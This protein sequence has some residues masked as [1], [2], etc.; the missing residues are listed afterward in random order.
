MKGKSIAMDEQDK[1]S[2]DPAVAEN[3]D[4]DPAPTAEVAVEKEKEAA[5]PAEVTM[6]KEK[7][8]APPTAEVID[9]TTRTKGNG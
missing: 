1:N 3:V 5:P 4:T 9:K 8:A 6:E 2:A 7:E